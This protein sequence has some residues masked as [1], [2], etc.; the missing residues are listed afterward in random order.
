MCCLSSQLAVCCTAPL[1]PWLKKKE[2]KRM[3]SCVDSFWFWFPQWKE[4]KPEELMDSKLRC[5]FELPLENE[6]T[7]ST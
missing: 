7:V 1:M 6:K 3:S 5:V 2:R 4:A